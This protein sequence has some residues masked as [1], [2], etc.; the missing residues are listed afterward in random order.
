MVD[1]K[2]RF[3]TELGRATMDCAACGAPKGRQNDYCLICGSSSRTDTG[4]SWDR[5][6]EA[7]CYEDLGSAL[8]PDETL[9]GATRGRVMGGWRMRA[10]L[11]PRVMMSP[12]ANIGLTSNRVIIQ[13]ALPANGR[14]VPNCVAAVPLADIHSITVAN[15]DPINPGRTVRIVVQMLTGETFRMRVS[16]RLASSASSMAE[17][18]R[19]LYTGERTG[20][21]VQERCEK[22]HKELD[23][24]YRF[25]PYCG[26]DQDNN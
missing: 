26:A 9:M 4:T 12:F 6:V 11:N 5:R 1:T 14:S 19:S 24:V 16:G 13:P 21:A 10:V 15:A 23:R 25:C 20:A 8:E 22:C 18:W 2:N 7:A 17:V 3:A